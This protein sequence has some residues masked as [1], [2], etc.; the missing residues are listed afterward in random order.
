MLLTTTTI[1]R[2]DGRSTRWARRQV[3]AGHF[4]PVMHRCRLWQYVDLANV[5]ASLGTKFTP[6]QIAAAQGKQEPHAKET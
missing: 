6:E 3:A 2:L 4:G 1:S 5:E